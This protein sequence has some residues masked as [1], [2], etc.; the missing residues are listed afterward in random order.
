MRN[1]EKEIEE[2]KKQIEEMKT[3]IETLK[4]DLDE[5]Y[6]SEIN[7]E[8]LARAVHELQ[9]EMK[10]HH[11]VLFVNEINAPTRVGR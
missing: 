7:T 6:E 8:L 5:L 9:D 2:M 10:K 3:E 11:D 4:N 1:M